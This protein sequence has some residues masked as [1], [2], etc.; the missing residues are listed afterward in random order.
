MKLKFIHKLA[1]ATADAYLPSEHTIQVDHVA[2]DVR[3][4]NN[5][6]IVALRGSDDDR[7]WG[8]NL[9]RRLIFTQYDGDV[10]IHSGFGYMASKVYLQVRDALD[11][12]KTVYLTGHSMGGALAQIISHDLLTDG[13][14]I[15]GCV[16]FGAPRVGNRK[17]AECL[18]ME[19]TPKIRVV[20]K[21]DVVPHLPSMF[22]G[23]K[24]AGQLYYLGTDGQLHIDP[25]KFFL[26]GDQVKASWGHVGRRGLSFF[27]HHSMTEYLEAISYARGIE[28]TA[29]P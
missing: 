23:Y 3:Q 8:A 18:N 2:V 25:S 21:N 9:D 28:S 22:G 20:L 27:E 1:F 7:D 17:F 15:W 14:L 4:K 19:H 29:V 11:K 13:F 6:Q 12:N 24:H 10:K 26:A 16:T 5:Y